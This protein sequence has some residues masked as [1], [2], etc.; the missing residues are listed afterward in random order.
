ML[1]K[2]FIGVV[3]LALGAC[4]RTEAVRTSANTMFVQTAAAPAC[5][6]VG[7]MRVAQ[8]MAAVETLRAGFDR[9]II[10]GG[11]AQ[12][13]V[14]VTQMPGTFRTTGTYGRGL[15]SANTTYQPGPTI[16][17]GTHDQGFTIVMFKDS[18]SGAQQAISARDTLG[19]DWRDKVKDGVRTCL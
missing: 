19:P 1:R 2:A 8:A 7:A 5:G 10:T 15:Y 14:S 16:V 4:A 13:N 9:Y 18:D 6:S 3:L 17:A 12:N 11:Q